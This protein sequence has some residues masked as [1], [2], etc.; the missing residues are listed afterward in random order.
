MTAGVYARRRLYGLASVSKSDD[1]GN[2]T[3]TFF[4]AKQSA[5]VDEG[6]GVGVGVDVGG[7]ELVELVEPVQEPYLDWQPVPQ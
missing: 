3:G 2:L 7:V 5:N 6:V 4:A 1:E